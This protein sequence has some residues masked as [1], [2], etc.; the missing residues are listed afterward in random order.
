[1]IRTM[2]GVMTACLLMCAGRMAAQPVRAV[3]RPPAQPPGPPRPEDGSAAPDGY[4][5]IPQWLGQTHA[6][7]PVRTAAYAV[8]TVAEGVNGAWFQFLPDGRMLV[9]EKNGRIRI[10]SQDGK[11]SSP[12][13][14]MPANMYT[15]GQSLYSVQPD[16]RFAAVATVISR[17]P[18][19][20]VEAPAAIENGSAAM[21]SK[22]ESE[23][24]VEIESP[25]SRSSY[26][27]WSR[28]MSQRP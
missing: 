8:E 2:A 14:G 9:A 24:H 25:E 11:L 13:G 3:P 21:S 17:S 12:L 4:A 1:M 19:T 27:S 15:V 20:L 6:A 10:V 16:R 28:A 18:V 5:P 26:S 23:R 7:L 22:V